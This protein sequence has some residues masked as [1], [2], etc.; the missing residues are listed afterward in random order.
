[1]FGFLFS[2]GLVAVD[3]ADRL[4]EQSHFRDYGGDAAAD[5]PDLPAGG[6]TGGPY[7]VTALSSRNRLH[8]LEQRRA[9]SQD[10]KTGFL[11]G[12]TPRAQQVAILFGALAS[13]SCWGRS[14]SS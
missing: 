1:V 12:A 7:Y 9:T 10:L 4:I 11:V 8:R 5:L 6:W 3:G 13:A 2:T 14:C